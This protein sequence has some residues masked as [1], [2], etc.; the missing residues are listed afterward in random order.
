LLAASRLLPWFALGKESSHHH[1]SCLVAQRR[2]RESADRYVLPRRR[3]LELQAQT[4][5][6]HATMVPTPRVRGI[7][8]SP[9]RTE[10]RHCLRLFH[11]F[12]HSLTRIHHSHTQGGHQPAASL[13]R[14]R[15]MADHEDRG[16]D[17]R[18]SG[19]HRERPHHHHPPHAHKHARHHHGHGQD[20]HA[21]GSASSSSSS[22]GVHP[23]LRLADQ[24][25]NLMRKDARVG[26][27][28]AEPEVEPER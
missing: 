11:L 9:R 12:I 27:P 25:E 23:L 15:R 18:T 28:S 1:A 8:N 17:R 16:G 10:Q 6:H 7:V 20:S 14:P 5:D 21:R 4:A 3:P 13:T 24:T 26:Y 19:G 22:S 2:E